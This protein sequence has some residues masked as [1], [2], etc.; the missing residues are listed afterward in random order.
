ME[1]QWLEWARKVQAL[2]QNG[3]AYTD[4]AYDRERY[5][6][7]R[8]VAL[9]MLAAGSGAELAELRGLYAGET[10]YATPK[11]DVRGVVFREGQLLLVKERVDGQW[12][13]PGG[14]AD[15]WDTPSQAVEREVWE[16][17][18][19]RVRAD[20]LLACWDRRLHGHPP[21]A[22][23]IY[24]LFFRCALLGGAPT[25]SMETDEIGFFAE[26]EVPELSLP[27]TTPWEIARLF[28]HLRNPALPAEY[29]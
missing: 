13:L 14:W 27:R 19:Y 20:K 26:G 7:L 2:A 18:G 8:E 24:K 5:E 4:S 22:F 1:P 10:G 28:E 25:Q 17:S 23:R 12:T 11:V 9:E 29:D 21:T 15:A 3:L 6:E 16:E